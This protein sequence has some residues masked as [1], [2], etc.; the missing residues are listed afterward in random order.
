MTD[1]IHALA[2]GEPVALQPGAL[3]NNG[4]QPRRTTPDN[5]AASSNAPDNLLREQ[6]AAAIEADAERPRDQRV[7]IINAI[8][9]VRDREMEQLRAK[10]TEIDHIINW[11]TT[12][13]SCARILDSSYAETMRA[14]TAEQRL[15]AADFTASHWHQAA[16]DRGD[17]PSA[18]A[19]ACIRAALNG[20]TRPD[21]LGIDDSLH[22]AFRIALQQPGEQPAQ[23]ATQATEPQETP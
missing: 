11:Q 17:I 5:S 19:I 13:A 4:E 14:E 21:Q 16:I 1:P 8:L 10:I 12:C 3:P 6:Y 18:H 20:E 2:F 7:G 15:Q 22:D 9:A 23:T